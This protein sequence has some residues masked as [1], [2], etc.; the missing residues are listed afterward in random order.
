MSGMS[1]SGDISTHHLWQLSFKHC[2]AVKIQLMKF[3]MFITLSML[4]FFLTNNLIF[5]QKSL[6]F[7]VHQIQI[8]SRIEEPLITWIQT[9][10]YTMD[11][12]NNGIRWATKLYKLRT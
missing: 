8:I 2:F 7:L 4:G 10:V 3:E 1:V 12:S 5:L 9:S 11:T 6:F